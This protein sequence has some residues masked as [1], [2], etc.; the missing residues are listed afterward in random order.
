MKLFSRFFF[1]LLLIA[2]AQPAPA[3][4][5]AN[6]ELEE[7]RRWEALLLTPCDKPLAYMTEMVRLGQTYP[8]QERQRLALYRGLLDNHRLVLANF[9][10]EKTDKTGVTVGPFR[11]RYDQ[12][13]QEAAR[14]GLLREASYEDIPEYQNMADMAVRVSQYD[15]AFDKQLQGSEA[16]VGKWSKKQ[17]N[18][19][20]KL[21]FVEEQRVIAERLRAE[22]AKLKED[23]INARS[24]YFRT[25][26]DDP[27]KDIFTELDRRAAFMT[28]TLVK[29]YENNR[30][31]LTIAAQSGDYL[32][33]LGEIVESS[34]Y[35]VISE[36]SGFSPPPANYQAGA[37]GTVEALPGMGFRMPKPVV[38]DRIKSA[39]TDIPEEFPLDLPL[40]FDPLPYI[41][42]EIECQ[43]IKIKAE[44]DAIIAMGTYLTGLKGTGGLIVGETFNVFHGLCEGLGGVG[45]ILI[46]VGTAPFKPIETYDKLNKIKD[47]MV[48]LW[49]SPDAKQAMV[50]KGVGSVVDYFRGIGSAVNLMA[51]PD[52]DEGVYDRY[53]MD[54]WRKRAEETQLAREMVTNSE[55][56]VGNIIADVL[57]GVILSKA[58]ASSKIAAEAAD[59]AGDLASA[60]ARADKVGDALTQTGKM[61]DDVPDAKTIQKL[62]EQISKSQ[63]DLLRVVDDVSV[64]KPRDI[65]YNQQMLPSPE[66][67]LAKAKTSTAKGGMNTYIKIDDNL[68]V[69][70]SNNEILKKLDDPTAAAISRAQRDLDDVGRQFLQ[71]VTKDSRLGRLPQVK[72]RYYVVDDLFEGTKKYTSIDDIPNG[73]RYKVVDV[74]E[75]IPPSSHASSLA[76][77]G[78]L[79]EN[80]IRAYEAFMRD[81][82]NKGYVWP[83]NKLDNFAF[84][85][86][87]EANGVYRVVPIDTGGVYKVTDLP[88]GADPADMARKIQ[89]AYDRYGERPLGHKDYMEVMLGEDLQAA[90]VPAE[91]AE[92]MAGKMNKYLGVNKVNPTATTV[93]TTNQPGLRLTSPDA[94]WSGAYG[95][96]ASKTD[97]VLAKELS[98]ATEASLATNADYLRARAALDAQ[99]AQLAD[100]GKK[101]EAAEQQLHQTELAAKSAVLN[102]TSS[103]PAAAGKV[104]DPLTGAAASRGAQTAKSAIGTVQKLDE[105]QEKMICLDIKEKILAGIQADWITEG[106]KNCQKLGLTFEGGR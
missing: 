53:T 85:A 37:P 2:L 76:K 94:Q 95:Q 12:L 24:E 105:A 104:I 21:F 72:D 46:G 100:A 1:I 55:K 65:P 102:T 9:L 82:N 57:T 66:E 16:S 22:M 103:A 74:V 10:T 59:T 44:K 20:N 56:I 47:G 60:R 99:K 71:D 97:D 73:A 18:V 81:M 80:H 29:E 27:Y 52:P 19:S 92:D 17:E 88:A 49:Q 31:A 13:Y 51:L 98:Q 28:D 25:M 62:G 87:D 11:A 39:Q 86:V 50:E 41:K 6:P 48:Y 68:G 58:S 83:D 78:K 14:E 54:E 96:V 3:R 5:A 67:V 30:Q 75:N 91:M 40:K 33:C 89:K 64:P 34:S 15:A 35:T 23:W 38:F 61:A 4:A 90:G 93:A 84:E 7:I 26:K 106:W 101:L 36:N 8:D 70:V 42:T 45:Q 77:Q 32:H 63:D 43:K 79:T 69:K